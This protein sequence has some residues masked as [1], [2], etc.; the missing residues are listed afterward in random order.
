MR[1]EVEEQEQYEVGG[2]EGGIQERRRGRGESEG[3]Y[4]IKDEEAKK[5]DEQ[6]VEV[7]RV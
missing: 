3:K 7:G 6:G 1:E 5:E 2:M 4:D